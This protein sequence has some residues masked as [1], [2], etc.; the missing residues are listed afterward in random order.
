MLS[1]MAGSS[2]TIA[3]LTCVLFSGN[4]SWPFP[5]PSTKK[6]GDRVRSGSLATAPFDHPPIQGAPLN[7]PTTMRFM[8]DLSLIV[9]VREPCPRT[10]GAEG[11]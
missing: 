9:G 8:T 10:Q 4:A 3:A 7:P 5:A 11:A 6:C 2:S 1:A